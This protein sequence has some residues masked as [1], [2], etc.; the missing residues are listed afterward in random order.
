MPHTKPITTIYIIRHCQFIDMA[1]LTS[2]L[3]AA[4]L[5]SQDCPLPHCFGHLNQTNKGFE[6]SICK[7]E[8]LTVRAEAWKRTRGVMESIIKQWEEESRI[9]ERLCGFW[10]LDTDE[11]ITEVIQD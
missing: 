10:E 11:Q 5:S 8:F 4:G 1:T 9:E 6:C 3:E 2:D 7:A